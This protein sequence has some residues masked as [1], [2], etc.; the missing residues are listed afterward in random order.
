MSIKSLENPNL[1]GGVS[2]AS[3]INSTQVKSWLGRIEVQLE[4]GMGREALAGHAPALAC[5][6]VIVSHQTWRRAGKVQIPVLAQGGDGEEMTCE[7]SFSHLRN[8][9]NRMGGSIFTRPMCDNHSALTLNTTVLAHNDGCRHFSPERPP[10]IT[11]QMDT[12]GKSSAEGLVLASRGT[13][14]RSSSKNQR[15]IRTV[16]SG[17]EMIT[18]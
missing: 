15:W 8:P 7:G 4:K 9:T 13:K 17:T 6:P 1:A 5:T 3:G 12:D 16:Q 18:W 14:E 2:L 11:S 10:R